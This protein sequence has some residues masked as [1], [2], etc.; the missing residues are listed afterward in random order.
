[1]PVDAKKNTVYPPWWDQ[2][3][4]YYLKSNNAAESYRKCRPKVGIAASE[5]SASKL[6]RHAKFKTVIDRIKAKT[7]K[8]FDLTREQWLDQMRAFAEGDGTLAA[9]VR[10]WEIVGKAVGHYSD[11]LN[12]RHSGEVYVITE[13]VQDEIAA[14][15]QRLRD[16]LPVLG[17]SQ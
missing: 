5:V 16:E 4:E 11:D 8:K 13:A 1:M 15:F 17:G 14:D 3:A 2:F 7:A 12:V 6:L 10:A 9:R